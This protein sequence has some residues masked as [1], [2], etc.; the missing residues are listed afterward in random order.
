MLLISICCCFFSVQAIIANILQIKV[1]SAS[2]H[3]V[4]AQAE[5]HELSVYVS[6]CWEGKL[7]E[8]EHSESEWNPPNPWDCCY[9]SQGARNFMH[10]SPCQVGASSARAYKL[11]G[12]LR[13]TGPCQAQQSVE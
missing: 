5:L 12:G 10:F 3:I 2:N 13:G 8:E 1:W 7:T 6:V 4:N 11:L 9:T